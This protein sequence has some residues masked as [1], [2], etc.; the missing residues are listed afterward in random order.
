MIRPTFTP[1]PGAEAFPI[2]SARHIQMETRPAQAPKAG[3]DSVDVLFRLVEARGR[4]GGP[5]EGATRQGELSLDLETTIVGASH[6][7]AIDGR[8]VFAAFTDAGAGSRPCVAKSAPVIAAPACPAM[9]CPLMP[10]AA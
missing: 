8:G 7:R 2:A 10:M 5:V 9:P 1:L 6:L 4:P 3:D